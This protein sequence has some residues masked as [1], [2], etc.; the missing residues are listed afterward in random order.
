MHNYYDLTSIPNFCTVVRR[1]CTVKGCARVDLACLI[2]FYVHNNITPACRYSRF[3]YNSFLF[4][5]I[6]MFKFVVELREGSNGEKILNS[7]TLGNLGFMLSKVG[8]LR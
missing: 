8:F 4:C 2:K 3:V 7:Y 5:V 6:R 1:C